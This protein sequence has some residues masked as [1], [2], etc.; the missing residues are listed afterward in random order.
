MLIKA[1]KQFKCSDIGQGDFHGPTSVQEDRSAEVTSTPSSEQR[2]RQTGE[3]L[4]KS[5]RQGESCNEGPKW[6]DAWLVQWM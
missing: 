2:R 6:G 1:L 5:V 3:C 4:R